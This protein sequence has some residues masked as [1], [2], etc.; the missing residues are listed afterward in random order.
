[1]SFHSNF[2]QWLAMTDKQNCPVCRQLPMPEGMV[3]IVELPN[4]W[5]NAEPVECLRG[6]C[7]LTSKKHVIEL[8][9][10]HDDELLAFMKEVQICAKALN[11][12]ERRKDR[13]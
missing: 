1:M 4:S 10:F 13:L 5:L 7:R 3:D 6:A 9:E 12:H 2:E 8:Y 11:H